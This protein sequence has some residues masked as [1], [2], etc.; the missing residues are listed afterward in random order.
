MPVQL[1]LTNDGSHT[2]YNASTDEN[3]HSIHGAVA[4]SRFVFL[5]A[6]LERC[7]KTE[8]RVLEIG[9]GTGLNAFLT[10][11]AAAANNQLVHYTSIEKFPLPENVWLQLNYAEM[12]GNDTSLFKRIHEIEW[13]T[14]VFLSSTFSLQKIQGDFCNIALEGNFDVIYFD[15]FSPERQPELW[16]DDIFRKLFRHS[17]WGGILTTYCA[18]GS[19]RRAM[20]AAGFTV[21]R[22][23]GPKGKREML[24]AT[25]LRPNEQ[26]LHH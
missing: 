3:Y 4:E 8:I 26:G 13:E 18:K 17:A 14:D 21:E 15:A 16:T 7:T 12:Y 1:L 9:F 6:G 5:Q 20:Q 10:A 24:R 2:L 23:P 11:L 22:L 25:K 19:V